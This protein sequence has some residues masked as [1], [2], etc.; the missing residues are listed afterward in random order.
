MTCPQKRRCALFPMFKQQAFLQVWQ[1]TYCDGSYEQCAR[2]KGA[3]CGEVIADTLLPNGKHLSSY[4]KAKT[5]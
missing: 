3:S 1:S 5:K 2:F 4:V